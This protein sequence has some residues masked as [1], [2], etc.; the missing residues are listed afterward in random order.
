MDFEK[1][2][3]VL[4]LGS[5]G[6]ALFFQITHYL[7]ISEAQVYALLFVFF[8]SGFAGFIK[9]ISF[10]ENLRAFVCFDITSKALSLFV[11]FV[12]AFG[13][14]SIPALYIFVDYC[15][16]FLILGEILSILICIQR[17]KARNK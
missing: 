10:R 2:N 11:P 1:S 3:A 4:F 6:L 5:G 15:F 14:K 8:F 17:L 12:V 7:G 16:S 9:T 13:A